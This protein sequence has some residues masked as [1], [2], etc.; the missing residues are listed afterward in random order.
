DDHPDDRGAGRAVARDP[1]GR[2]VVGRLAV[3]V[4][5]PVLVDDALVRVSHG[6]WVWLL[7]HSVE[8]SARSARPGVGPGGRGEVRRAER[9]CRPDYGGAQGLPPVPRGRSWPERLSRS[10]RSFSFIRSRS[11]M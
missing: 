6:V 3:H 4:L 9:G 10:V 5:E 1:F 11:F 8:L 7:H 2:A